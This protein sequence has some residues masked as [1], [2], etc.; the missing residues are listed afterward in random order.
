MNMEDLIIIHRKGVLIYT[1]SKIQTDNKCKN[2]TRC[3][4]KKLTKINLELRR[5]TSRKICYIDSSENSLD[6]NRG[7]RGS[8]DEDFSL[9]TM[10]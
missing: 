10:S 3:W 2:D 5:K 8:T 4:K 1:T 9:H 6:W 7:H